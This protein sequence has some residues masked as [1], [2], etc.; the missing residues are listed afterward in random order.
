MREG[1]GL[2]LN[3]QSRILPI[4]GGQ[5]GRAALLEMQ[6]DS[7]IAVTSGWGAADWILRP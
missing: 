7:H 3:E 6:I 1:G 4:A 5:P 2:T